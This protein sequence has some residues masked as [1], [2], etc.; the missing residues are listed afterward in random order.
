MQMEERARDSAAKVAHL[1]QCLSELRAAIRT[2]DARVVELSSVHS[3]DVAQRAHQW[4]E[5]RR[6]ELQSHRAFLQAKM[7]AILLNQQRR[8][9][10]TTVT[11]I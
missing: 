8:E 2:H 5:R 4:Q 7:E 1:E 3:A 6:V 11:R 9:G 10:E